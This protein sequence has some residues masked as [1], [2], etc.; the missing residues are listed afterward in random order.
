MILIKIEPQHEMITNTIPADLRVEG[1]IVESTINTI[2][3]STIN[4]IV[5]NMTNTINTITASTIDM[6]VANMINLTSMTN[7]ISMTDMTVMISR[8]IRMVKIHNVRKGYLEHSILDVIHNHQTYI[9][10]Y[11]IYIYI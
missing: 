7:M 8:V 6:T 10:Y 5:E 1:T 11:H 2:V 9:K 3:E 4:M